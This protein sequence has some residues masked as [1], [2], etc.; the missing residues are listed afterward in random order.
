[1][2]TAWMRSKN[3]VRCVYPTRRSHEKWTNERG[4]FGG[5]IE[6]FRETSG[7]LVFRFSLFSFIIALLLL[8][9]SSFIC[10]FHIFLCLI[11]RIQWKWWFVNGP[12]C[13]RVCVWVYVCFVYKIR[14]C[15]RD[16]DNH[17]LL[18]FLSIVCFNYILIYYY[19]MT[20]Y[21]HWSKCNLPKLKPMI[22][23]LFRVL[24]RCCQCCFYVSFSIC[25]FIQS[26]LTKKLQ[27]FYYFQIEKL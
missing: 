2:C 25:Y 10:V 9:F 4:F 21:G 11:L 1:M 8:L 20:I 3:H 15:Y 14:H 19:F 12:R 23:A 16:A 24:F 7:R 22:N 27:N 26:I 18:V 5:I 13:S 6:V 17:F